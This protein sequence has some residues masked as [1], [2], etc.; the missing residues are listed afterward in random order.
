MKN[1]AFPKYTRFL[2]RR[3]IGLFSLRPILTKRETRRGAAGL[4]GKTKRA[5]RGSLFR[6]A[7]F[8]RR[9]GVLKRALD[10]FW[11]ELLRYG[12]HERNDK[13]RK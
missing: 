11:L 9:R 3:A 4:W 6:R 13:E 1:A 12:A 2:Q 7:L 5:T 10:T 8:D